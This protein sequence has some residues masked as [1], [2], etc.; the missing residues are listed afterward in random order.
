VAYVGNQPARGQWRKLSDISS[1]FDGVIT[2]FTTSVPPGTSQYFVTAGSA[3]QLLISLGGVIQEPDVDY[4]VSTNS[5]TFT[6]PP[7]S[8]LSFFGVLCG[9]AL[10]AGVPSDGS[11]TTSKLAGGLS[12][13]LTGGSVST[14]SL[15]FTGD[16]NTGVFSAGADQLNI[17]TNGVERVEFGT[18]EVVFNDGGANYDF[19]IEGD[20]NAN[21]FFVDASAEAVGIGTSSPGGKLDVRD[22]GTTIPAL[23][24]VGTGLNVRRTDGAIGLIIG[25]ENAVGGS[26][27][28]AQ[29]TNG[30][31]AAYPLYL[32]PNGGNVG[33][34]TTSPALKLHVEDSGSQVV[35]WTRTG[36]GAGSLDVDAS[37]NAV[38]NAHTSSTGIAFHLQASE[39]ARLDSSGRFLVGTSSA[40]TIFENGAASARVQVEGTDNS[41]S[42]LTVIRNGGGGGI[43]LAGTAGASVGSIDAVANNATLGEIAF[44]GSDGTDFVNAANISAHVDG[45]PGADDMPGRIV[46]STTADGSASPTERAR[47]SSTGEWLVYSSGSDTLVAGNTAGSGTSQSLFTGVHTRTSTT[48]GGTVA[49]RI[50]NNGTTFS[51]S[52]ARQ[53]KNVETARDGYLEDLQQLR[54]VKYNWLDQADT[55]SK[56][57]GLLAQEVAKVF[58]GLVQS[59]DPSD[60]ESTL[61][62]KSSVFSFMLIKALQEAGEKIEALE[63]RL[64]ALE[65]Q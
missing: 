63:T 22:A 64:A 20:T 31:A 35:R 61:G 8:G 16:D 62:I 24:A 43:T 3:S 1:A 55:E 34:G 50:Y 40:R 29:H 19:R 58:P 54:V 45:T 60:P 48:G 53:K 41:T 33:I 5:V 4:T 14:P 59:A 42:R 37:G 7:T 46:F 44:A 32:Q 56:E 52:D 27:I 38:V 49:Y 21:L 17:A 39:K 25:Y 47:L 18:S 51:I 26:Y 11:V 30:S 6:T 9:D 10:N 36:V 12:V 57:L 23:G 65:A 28:Q 2:T 15:F 13:G